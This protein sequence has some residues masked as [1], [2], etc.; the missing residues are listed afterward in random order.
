MF[1]TYFKNSFD[2]PNLTDRTNYEF[3]Q[4]NQD[5]AKGADSV[6]IVIEN[7]NNFSLWLGEAK[8]YTNIESFN[9]FTDCFDNNF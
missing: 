1:N 2:I 6:H 9:S 8:F 5:N 7:E 3:K 4:N